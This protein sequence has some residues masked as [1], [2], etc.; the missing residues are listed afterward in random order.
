MGQRHSPEAKKPSVKELHEHYE[1]QISLPC[2]QY[3]TPRRLTTKGN[4]RNTPPPPHSIYLKP[5]KIPYTTKSNGKT[6]EK[7]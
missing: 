6:R 5:I 2:K 1:S 7:F 3:P 4:L